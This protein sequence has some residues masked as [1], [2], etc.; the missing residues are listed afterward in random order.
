MSWFDSPWVNILLNQAVTVKT[1]ITDDKL[2]GLAIFPQNA[3][4]K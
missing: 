2:P 1:V 3:E 4:K